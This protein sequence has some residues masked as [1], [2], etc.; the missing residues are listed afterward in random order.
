MNF[1]MGV[2]PL[3][4]TLLS[5]VTKRRMRQAVRWNR[6]YCSLVAIVGTTPHPDAEEVIWNQSRRPAPTNSAGTDRLI[7]RPPRLLSLISKAC[8]EYVGLCR[9][10]GFA[11]DT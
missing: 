11:P 6:Q 5:A 7:W 9:S 1:G 2:V 3:L 4:N 10:L 8:A